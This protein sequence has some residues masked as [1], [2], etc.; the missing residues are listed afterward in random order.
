MEL[1]GIEIPKLRPWSDFAFKEARFGWFDYN[2]IPKWNN[3]M[4]NNLLYYQSNYFVLAVALSIVSILANPAGG[5]IGH[6]LLAGL[7]TVMIAYYNQSSDK[8][9]LGANIFIIL[10]ILIYRKEFIYSLFFVLLS[11]FLSMVH[12]SFRLRNIKNRAANLIG[13][14]NTPM[15]YL[16]LKLLNLEVNDNE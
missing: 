6:F 16:L 10:V 2:N 12:A 8:R 4:M 14:T 1:C 11:I 9:L 15:G 13:I 7:I 3:R 5:I